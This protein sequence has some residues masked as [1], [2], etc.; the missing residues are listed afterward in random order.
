M[1]LDG[2]KGFLG[3]VEEP[4]NGF[5]ERAGSDIICKLSENATSDKVRGVKSL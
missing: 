1:E 3:V 5:E 2:A 4:P